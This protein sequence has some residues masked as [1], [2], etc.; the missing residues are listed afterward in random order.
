VQA[1]PAVDVA[2]AAANVKP[3]RKPSGVLKVFS[4]KQLQRLP[5][6]GYWIATEGG[7]TTYYC[8][9][10]GA[11]KYIHSCHDGDWNT[12]LWSCCPT[13]K[14]IAASPSGTYEHFVDHASMLAG[15]PDVKR[16]ARV[17]APNDL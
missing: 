4:E 2:A 6:A 13:A 17:K 8:V 15:R 16:G 14:Q 12:L 11:V 5:A 1:A 10:N 9:M 7:Y 3:P